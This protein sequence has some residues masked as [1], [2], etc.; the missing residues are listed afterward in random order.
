MSESPR[1]VVAAEPNLFSAAQAEDFPG[2]SA[3]T[4]WES[5][6][7]DTTPPMSQVGRGLGRE[8]S[9]GV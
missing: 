3:A 7:G 1:D 8:A 5:L 9:E 6:G 2:V 4:P